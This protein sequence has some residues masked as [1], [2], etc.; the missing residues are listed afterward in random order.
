MVIRD[1][2]EAEILRLHHV[3]KWGA[4]DVPVGAGGP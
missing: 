4:P 3:E 2:V 1:E